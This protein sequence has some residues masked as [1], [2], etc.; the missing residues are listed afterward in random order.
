MKIATIA[1]LCFA[2]G[3]ATAIAPAQTA[4]TCIAP[5]RVQN[6]VWT[7]LNTEYAPVGADVMPIVPDPGIPQ[8]M[9]GVS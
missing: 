7:D 6:A 5:A 4:K 3:F 2:A 9:R 1:T 8:N